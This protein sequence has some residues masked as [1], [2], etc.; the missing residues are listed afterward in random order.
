MA[1]ITDLA[2]RR[3]LAFASD[4]ELA[5]TP[6]GDRE[7]FTVSGVDAAALASDLRALLTGTPDLRAG[8]EKAAEIIEHNTISS[9]S[10]GQE[11]APRT[12]GDKFG[13]AYAAA[14]RQAAEEA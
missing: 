9:C 2:R 12:D 7:P 10:T 4:L 5:A 13:L 6:A 1:E 3:L 8:M 11:I 14:I